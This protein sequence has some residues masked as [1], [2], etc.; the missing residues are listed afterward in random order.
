MDKKK[1]EIL[2]LGSFIII[3]VVFVINVLI[4]RYERQGGLSV[5]PG[6]NIGK[7]QIKKTTAP[8][9]VSKPAVIEEESDTN[10]KAQPGG[11]LLQ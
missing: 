3:V 5:N 11:A 1:I 9:R 2:V 4:A 10:A 6:K 7:P 8:A